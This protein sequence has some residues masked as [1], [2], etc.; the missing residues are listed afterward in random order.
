MNARTGELLH[1]A[2]K[3][4]ESDRVLLADA[5]YASLDDSSD[6]PEQVSAAWDAEIER[7]VA[8]IKS[9]T[10]KTVLADEIKARLDSIIRRAQAR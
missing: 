10:A 5:L 4:P 6:S 7:R 1:E 8:E 3:L 9:G 2:I